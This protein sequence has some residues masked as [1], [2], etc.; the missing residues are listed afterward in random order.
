MV[1]AAAAHCGL[2][3]PRIDA[4]RQRPACDSRAARLSP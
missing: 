3:V 4:I 1:H 2:F